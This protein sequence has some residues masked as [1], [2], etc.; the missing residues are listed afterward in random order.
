MKL[1]PCKHCGSLAHLNK[2]VTDPHLCWSVACSNLVCGISTRAFSQ[3]DM[4]VDAWQRVAYSHRNGET[5]APTVP[6]KYWF[7]GI[8]THKAGVV[9][10]ADIV[11][12][13]EDG[14]IDATAY[15]TSPVLAWDGKWWGPI[16]AP[17]ESAE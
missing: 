8:R 3:Q 6:G 13:D 16:L 11:N 12:V 4:A 2:N 5:E 15:W 9:S 7:D 14:E 10:V 1:S 17:R